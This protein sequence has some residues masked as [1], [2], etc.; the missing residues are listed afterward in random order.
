MLSDFQSN[1]DLPQIVPLFPLSGALLLPRAQL[2]LRIFEP[3]YLDMVDEAMRQEHRLIGF[4]QPR[5]NHSKSLENIGCLGRITQLNETHD[6]HYYITLTGI[7][8]FKI[9]EELP[10]RHAFREGY[11]EGMEEDFSP[12]R[13]ENEVDREGLIKSLR[14]FLNQNNLDADWDDIKKTTTELLV[15]ALSVMS[16]W[17]SLE[18]QALLEAKS[19]KERADLLIAL[20]ERAV[21]VSKRPQSKTLQ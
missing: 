15:N 11:I 21:Q 2:P 16:P 1:D 17:G 19:L 20:S 8:R 12:G 7:C 6:G 13:G 4:V 18:K 14:A 10:T 3:R 9:I 5:P